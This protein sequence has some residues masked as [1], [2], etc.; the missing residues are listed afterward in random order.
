MPSPVF[1]EMRRTWVGSSPSRS[2]TSTAVPSGSAAGRSILFA[3]GTISSPFSIARYALASVCASMPCAA[4]TTRSAPSHAWSERETSYVK[5]T[6][7]GVSMRLSSWPFQR[8]ADGLRLDRD[9]PFPL[10]LHRVENLRPHVARRDGLGQLEDPV[11]ERRLAVVDVRDDREVA[12]AA[13]VHA[14]GDG[15]GR[16]FEPSEARSGAG[17]PQP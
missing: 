1:A 2:A 6:C 8:D 11:G 3:T 9:S 4:S 15:T 13:L 16:P 7:P 14:V 17:A 5:S 12:D 10:E